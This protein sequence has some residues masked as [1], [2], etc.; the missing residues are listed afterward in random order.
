MEKFQL[1]TAS[2]LLV[3]CENNNERQHYKCASSRSYLTGY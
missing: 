2:N 3:K 1:E